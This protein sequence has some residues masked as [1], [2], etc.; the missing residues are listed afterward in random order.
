MIPDALTDPSRSCDPL[1]MCICELQLLGQ[2]LDQYLKNYYQ[3]QRVYLVRLP[4][5]IL[6]NE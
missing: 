4:R 3:G 6:L 5:F 2:V 1:S